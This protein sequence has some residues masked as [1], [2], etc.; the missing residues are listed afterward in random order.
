MGSPVVPTL[1]GPASP[2]ALRVPLWGGLADGRADIRPPAV[3]WGQSAASS[4][5]TPLPFSRA[6]PW[7]RPGALEGLLACT[8]VPRLALSNPLFPGRCSH[9]IHCFVPVPPGPPWQPCALRLG[10]AVVSCC[11]LSLLQTPGVSPADRT[12]AGVSG[13][14]LDPCPGSDQCP[15]RERCRAWASAW[16]E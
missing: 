10:S 1:P 6:L 3:P 13:S 8:S 7:R 5:E 15:G 16:L 11:A 14:P 2:A 9:G 12:Y 4:P